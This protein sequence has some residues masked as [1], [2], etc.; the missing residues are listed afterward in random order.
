MIYMP[1]HFCISVIFHDEKSLAFI[2]ILQAIRHGTQIAHWL[3]TSISATQ[4]SLIMIRLIIFSILFV[5]S[6]SLAHGQIGGSSPSKSHQKHGWSNQRSSIW[7]GSGHLKGAAPQRH[8]RQKQFV[9]TPVFFDPRLN[10]F[11]RS[12]RNSSRT[13][14]FSSSRPRP[15]ATRAPAQIVQAPATPP[16]QK[17]VVNP[18]FDAGSDTEQLASETDSID[19]QSEISLDDRANQEDSLIQAS[20]VL[21]STE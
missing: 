1:L 3:I 13:G 14:S 9:Q 12:F 2:G 21:E 7:K 20:S 18:F 5:T 15:I 10:G 19:Q 11:R 6:N 17:L 16:E 4:Q 8:V